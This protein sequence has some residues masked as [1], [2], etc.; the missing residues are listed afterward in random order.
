M[1]PNRHTRLTPSAGAPLA[2][3]I[4]TGV[5]LVVGTSG[6]FVGS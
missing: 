2:Q 1:A 5:L 4:W 3:R 6:R